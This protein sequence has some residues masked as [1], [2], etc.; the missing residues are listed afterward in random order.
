MVTTDTVSKLYSKVI[1][2][3]RRRILEVSSW[4]LVAITEII[5]TYF[6]VQ[7]CRVSSK[8]KRKLD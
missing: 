5:C 2:G 7:C 1:K 8:D 4:L 3:G 6:V